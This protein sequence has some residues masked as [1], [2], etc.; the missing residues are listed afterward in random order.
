[1][2]VPAITLDD[3]LAREKVTKIDFL[4]MDIEE[5]EPAALAGFDIGKYAPELVCIEIHE[6]VG[7]KIAAYMS[8]HGYVVVER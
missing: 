4:S 3:L 2:K 8:A 1:V 7:D 6:H 5:G